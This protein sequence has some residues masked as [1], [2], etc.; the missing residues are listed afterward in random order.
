M[1]FTTEITRRLTRRCTNHGLDSADQVLNQQL[2]MRVH[3]TALRLHHT[4]TEHL[5]FNRDITIDVN[6]VRINFV[7]FKNEIAQSAQ[8]VKVAE[9]WF[10]KSAVLLSVVSTLPPKPFQLS[11]LDTNTRT[12]DHGHMN[13]AT[14]SMYKKYGRCPTKYASKPGWLILSAIV[15]FH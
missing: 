9:N 11:C 1:L 5:Q 12:L 14:L 6:L 2:Q 13:G 15:L 4:C 7:D 8:S 3:S 10:G